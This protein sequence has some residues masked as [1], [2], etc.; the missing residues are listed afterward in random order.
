[1]L[2]TDLADDAALLRAHHRPA[3]ACR[4]ESTAEGLCPVSRGLWLFMD[5]HRHRPHL[6]LRRHGPPSSGNHPPTEKG[7]CIRPATRTAHLAVCQAHCRHLGIQ[8]SRLRRLL[9]A[10]GG[11]RIWFPVLCT[12][13]QRHH[14]G[15]TGG[16]V[17]YQ[18]LERCLQS[19]SAADS[20]GSAAL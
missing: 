19:K 17:S 6:H 13:F 1:M 15:R 7:R 9:P 8:R 5:S 2:A 20:P 10:T 12:A 4:T 18:C 11:Q 16:V 3:P 14:A